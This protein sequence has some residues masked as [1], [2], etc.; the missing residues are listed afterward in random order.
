MNKNMIGAFREALDAYINHTSGRGWGHGG[1]PTAAIKLRSEESPQSKPISA[2]F[3]LVERSEVGKEKMARNNFK[4]VFPRLNP[5]AQ[6]ELYRDQ[7]YAC[8]AKILRRLIEKRNA[9]K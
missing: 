8:A 6:D 5:E 1:E 9:A 2:I 7:T 3:L 4:R